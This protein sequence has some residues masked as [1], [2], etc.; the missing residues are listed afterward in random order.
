MDPAEHPGPNR[1]PPGGRA[2]LRPDGH[3][4]WL[5]RTGQRPDLN[6]LRTALTTWLG[7]ADPDV[8]GERKANSND[9]EV[10]ARDR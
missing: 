5:T 8:Q 6:G 1:T 4:A 3:V 2:H 7:P 10:P 9:N